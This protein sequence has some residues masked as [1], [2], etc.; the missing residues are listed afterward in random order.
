MSER[1]SGISMA[2]G[3]GLALTMAVVAAIWLTWADC[4]SGHSFW[5]CLVALSG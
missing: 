5:F 3:L 4:L 1:K 2:F